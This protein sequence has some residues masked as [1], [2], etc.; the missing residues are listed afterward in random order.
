MAITPI[1]GLP[2]VTYARTLPDTQSAL[3]HKLDFHRLINSLLVEHNIYFFLF[4]L[5][6]SKPKKKPKLINLLGCI[7]DH[8]SSADLSSPNNYMVQNLNML[9]Y[10][11]IYIYFYP[12]VANSTPLVTT[13]SLG[14]DS[15]NSN[16][17]YL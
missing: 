8:F 4:F 5:T 2:I 10:I 14:A 6:Q 12:V 16:F 11:Y 17:F 9:E 3:S 1:V 13:L 15:V 7:M